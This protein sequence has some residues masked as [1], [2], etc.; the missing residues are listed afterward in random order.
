[1]CF[2]TYVRE[3]EWKLHFKR[4]TMICMS[5]KYIM[6]ITFNNWTTV[7]IQSIRSSI[8]KKYSYR[9]SNSKQII[10]RHKIPLSEVCNGMLD[11]LVFVRHFDISSFRIE[12]K[13]LII[14]EHSK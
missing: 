7:E 14:I 5:W 3:L 8:E 11:I 4:C 6:C 12:I 13:H 9:T 10:V 1:M 2:G